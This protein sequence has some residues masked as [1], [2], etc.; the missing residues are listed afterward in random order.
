MAN[1]TV[2]N[3]RLSPSGPEVTGGGSVGPTGPTG[4]TGPVGPTGPTGPTGPFIS[5]SDTPNTYSGAA[6]QFPRVNE[7]EDGLS[8]APTALWNAGPLVVSIFG[9]S[10]N[11]T[12]V[13]IIY[14]TN[15]QFDNVVISNIYGNIT[16][17]GAGNTWINFNIIAPAPLDV[18]RAMKT[19]VSTGCLQDIDGS[20]IAMCTGGES[21]FHGSL[22]LL[23]ARTEFGNVSAAVTNARFNITQ[24]YVLGPA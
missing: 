13:G 22:N 16:T 2:T 12:D 18:T 8:F 3:N 11:V 17:N 9:F 14:A 6:G 24:Y 4:P 5:L 20:P 15:I 1:P 7:T 23:R 21:S 19:A 10:N